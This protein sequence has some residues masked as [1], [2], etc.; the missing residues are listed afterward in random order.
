MTGIESANW[1]LSLCGKEIFE[2][3]SYPP[4]EPLAAWIEALIMRGRK[5]R[6]KTKMGD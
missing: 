4:P 1:V 6:K 2:L 5:K 3:E